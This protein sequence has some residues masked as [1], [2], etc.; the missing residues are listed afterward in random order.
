MFQL[1]L[2]TYFIKNT[3]N[4]TISRRTDDLSVNKN[5]LLKTITS[6]RQRNYL[7]S[8]NYFTKLLYIVKKLLHMVKKLLN[9]VKKLLHTVKKLLHM[10]KIWLNLFKKFATYSY[11]IATSGLKIGTYG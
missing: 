10:V 3:I 6:Y 5:S 8:E 4:I 2:E 7:L 11:K 9:M 1:L